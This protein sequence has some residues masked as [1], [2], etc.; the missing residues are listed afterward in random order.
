[1]GVEWVDRDFWVIDTAYAL[2]L[3]AADVDLRFAYYLIRHVGLDH[4]KYGTSN[5]S[6]TRDAFGTQFFPVPPIDDQRGIAA[7]L[8]A[9]DD[10]IESNRRVMEIAGRLARS[11]VDI[12]VADHDLVAYAD[13]VEVH[14]GSAFKGSA[15]TEPG[16]GR[17]LLR[18]RDLKTFEPQTWTTETRRDETVIHPGDIVVGMDAEFR[19][20]LWLGQDSVLNQR[21]CSFVGRPGV[22]RAFILAALEPELAFQESAKTGTTVIHLNKS[23]IDTFLVPALSADEHRRLSEITEPLIDIVVARGIENRR[24]AATRDSL[25]PGLLSGLIRAPEAVTEIVI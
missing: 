22:S 3:I 20:T 19:A 25:L 6:L 5:P 18:I 17:P 7:T 10:K 15:F 23:D 11:H 8:S 2:A 16:T 1:L 4:L 12:A 13:A 9:L 14:M 24:L 21:V